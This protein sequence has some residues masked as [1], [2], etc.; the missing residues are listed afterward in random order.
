MKTSL[1]LLTIVLIIVSCSPSN[2]LEHLLSHH[3]ELMTKDTLTFRDTIIIPETKADTFILIN[4][5]TDTVYLNKDNLQ[6]TLKRVHDT[7]YIQGKCKGD[8]IY[9]ERKIPVER[10]KL[11]KS[12][13]LDNLITKLPW[14]ITGLISLIILTIFLIHKL[15]S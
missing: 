3:P 7:L 9:I 2:R 14:L 11:V 5:L 15:K 13:K 4:S 6:I 1:F 8:T 12:D 10:I